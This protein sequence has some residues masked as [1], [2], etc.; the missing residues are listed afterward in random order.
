LPDYCGNKCN[1]SRRRV[2]FSGPA[3]GLWLVTEM[4]VKQTG[5]KVEK[6]PGWCNYHPG[7]HTFILSNQD[8]DTAR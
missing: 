1:L 6:S 2:P 4:V 8:A 5:G 7:F 3:G